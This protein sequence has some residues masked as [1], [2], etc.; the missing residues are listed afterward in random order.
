MKLCVRITR[1]HEGGY[2]ALCPTLPG[3]MTQGLTR[4]EACERIDD[5]IRGY[6]AAVGNFVPENVTREIVEV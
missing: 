1:N 6:L 2:T 3:C 5:A 4:E